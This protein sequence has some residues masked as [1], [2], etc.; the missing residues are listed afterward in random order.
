MKEI[1][2]EIEAVLVET[3]EANCNVAQGYKVFKRLKELRLE[4]K[5]KN[6]ELNCLYALTDY[7]DCQSL[8]DVCEDNLAVIEKI[9]GVPEHREVTPM[10]PEAD[11]Q[12]ENMYAAE[13]IE[14]MV[15]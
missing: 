11:E 15:G 1:D 8:A 6:R 5:A 14:D 9:I 7:I 2:D 10:Q 12:E 13:N 3:E 4:K